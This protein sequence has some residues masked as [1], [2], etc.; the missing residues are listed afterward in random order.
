LTR[1]EKIGRLY[2]LLLR[3]LMGLACILLVCAM[4]LVCADVFMRYLFN[5][6]IIWAMDVCGFLLVGIV[7]VGMAWL[8]REQAHVRMDFLVDRLAPRPRAGLELVMSVVAVL[9]LAVILYYGLLEI[10]SLSQRKYAVETGILRIH[11]ITLLIPIAFGLALFLIEFI[12]Q[13][14]LNFRILTGAE[15]GRAPAEGRPE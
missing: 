6:P 1:L 15:N 2:D 12:R 14:Y 7:S 8:L 5:A 3:G 13:I 11:K 10:G 9:T 4:L